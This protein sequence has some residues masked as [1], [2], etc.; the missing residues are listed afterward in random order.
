MRHKLTLAMHNQPA[1]DV[2]ATSRVAFVE[3]IESG[4]VSALQKYLC[5]MLTFCMKIFVV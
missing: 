5:H 1:G 4:S 3:F 2:T